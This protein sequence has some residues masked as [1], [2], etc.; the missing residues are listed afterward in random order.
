MTSVNHVFGWSE[1]RK[2]EIAKK[3]HKCK[4]KTC[5]VNIYGKYL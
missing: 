1:R 2:N 5:G 4:K 3:P